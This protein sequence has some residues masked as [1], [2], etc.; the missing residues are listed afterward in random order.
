MAEDESRNRTILM[1]EDFTWCLGKTCLIEK[2]S[3]A[4]GDERD[5]DDGGQPSGV[6]IVEGNHASPM[7]RD[8]AAKSGGAR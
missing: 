3:D 1:G 5:R 4:A 7:L 8:G 6:I 2:H